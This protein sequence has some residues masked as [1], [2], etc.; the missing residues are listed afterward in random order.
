M[1][2]LFLILVLFFSSPL[3]ARNST[4]EVWIQIPTGEKSCEGGGQSLADAKKEI[5]ARGLKILKFCSGDD[6]LMHIQ[7]CGAD[8]GKLH[9]FQ[10]DP[11]SLKKCKSKNCGFE[12]ARSHPCK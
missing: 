6:G 10:V 2:K 7:V 11:S 8:A 3:H 5:R 4:K 1:K 12:L 9:F